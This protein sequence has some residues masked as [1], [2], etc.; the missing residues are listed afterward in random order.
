M[1]KLSPCIVDINTQGCF[2]SFKNKPE[3]ISPCREILGADSVNKSCVL[4]NFGEISEPKIQGEYL[5][6]IATFFY[7][8]ASVKSQVEWWDYDLCY[9]DGLGGHVILHAKVPFKE[10]NEMS[11]ERSTPIPVIAHETSV[12]SGL[13]ETSWKRHL[14]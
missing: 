9:R 1:R 7:P 6:P 8:L 13:E 14:L 12:V 5:T 10:K 2:F 4:S 3:I 11:W